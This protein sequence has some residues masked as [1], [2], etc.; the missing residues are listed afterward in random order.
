MK[1]IFI[2]SYGWPIETFIGKPI[3]SF[4]RLLCQFIRGN[5]KVKLIKERK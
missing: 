3:K 5:L 1:I 4:I 2:D